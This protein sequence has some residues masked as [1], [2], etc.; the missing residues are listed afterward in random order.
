MYHDITIKLIA[1]NLW[2]LQPTQIL[3]EKESSILGKK[4]KVYLYLE[5][6][7]IFHD[8]CTTCRSGKVFFVNK[9]NSFDIDH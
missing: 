2:Y 4:K 8:G 5:K 3:H 6:A 1:S 7:K 9:K